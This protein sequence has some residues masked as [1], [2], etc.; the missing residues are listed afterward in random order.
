MS[1]ASRAQIAL[2]HRVERLEQ[3]VEDLTRAVERLN[4]LVLAQRHDDHVIEAF[5]SYDGSA[6]PSVDLHLDS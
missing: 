6:L 3:H 2:E 5:G 4:A 1:A